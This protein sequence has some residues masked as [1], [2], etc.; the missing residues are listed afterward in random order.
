MMHHLILFASQ[1]DLSPLPNAG[2]GFIPKVLSVAIGIIAAVCL[3][4]IVIGGFRYILSEGD[5]QGVAKAKGTIIYAL[6]GLV[7]VILAQAIVIFVI[8]GVS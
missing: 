1:I 5:P 6:I 7:V 3:L 8:K 2:A 4:F